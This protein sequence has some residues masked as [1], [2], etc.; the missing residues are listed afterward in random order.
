MDTYNES[1][2]LLAKEFVRLLRMSGEAEIP[3]EHQ[4]LAD[5][6]LQWNGRFD[7]DNQEAVSFQ[8]FY[9]HF[10]TS[11]YRQTRAKA[12]A[13]RILNSDHL[14]SF[15]LADIPLADTKV[16]NKS[17]H[18][19]L[20]KTASQARKY[21]TW[22]DL[23]QLNL[24]HSLGRIPLVGK[25]FQFGTLPVSGSNNTLLKT[26]H[27]L[28]NKAHNTTYGANS[29]MVVFMHDPNANYFILMGGQDG[30]IGSPALTDQ[31][32]LWQKGEYLKLPL[33]WED[34]KK[35]FK[36]HKFLAPK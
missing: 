16:V 34:V 29:R 11:F 20:S 4:S 8:L 17:L 7:A 14:I 35:E 33:L 19:A 25:R 9:Y 3:M 13:E 6:L 26:A 10:A 27:Q 21:P 28:T 12:F 5:Q 31:V 36:H 23:H 32:P 22:G 18:K 24:A 15:L 2:H 30:W 1:A